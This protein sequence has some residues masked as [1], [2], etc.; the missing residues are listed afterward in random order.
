V[1]LHAGLFDTF[2]SRS[3]DLVHTD[4]HGRSRGIG[5]WTVYFDRWTIVTQITDDV[6]VLLVTAFLR[7]LILYAIFF[8]VIRR[9]IGQPLQQLALQ[10]RRLNIDNLDSQPF[11]LRDRGWHELHALTSVLNMMARKI[12]GSVQENTRLVEELTEINATLQARVEQRTRELEQLATTDPLTGL[13][14]RRKLD[15]SLAYE[16]LRAERFN[17][18]FSLVII[19]LDH[20][21]SVNDVHGHH[22]GDLVLQH[23]AK[24]LR[25]TTRGTDIIGRW[26]GEEFLVICPH[27]TREE[28]AILAERV[29]ATAVATEF[30]AVG[31]QTCSIGI[32]QFAAGEDVQSAL[33][34]ADAALYRAKQAGR[35]RFEL[36]DQPT[37]VP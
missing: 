21:K 17:N 13:A 37:R 6:E 20:F 10:V 35:N 30:P 3:F 19:D 26:G 31:L 29:R 4:P 15:Q 33:A 22:A 5:E 9:I 27:T 8:V 16:R 23:F 32:A 24:L 2:F 12:R 18:A 36:A 11:T 1:A 34:R 25:G 14:N 7:T 28:A